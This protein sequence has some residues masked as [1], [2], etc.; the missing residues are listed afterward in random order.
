MDLDQTK[1]PSL[2][3]AFLDTTSS[4]VE[5]GFVIDSPS[6]ECCRRPLFTW[7][8]SNFFYFSKA[9]MYLFTKLKRCIFCWYCLPPPCTF[10]HMHISISL[11]THAPAGMTRAQFLNV[12]Y[13]SLETLEW[14]GYEGRKKEKEVAA[15][16]LRSGRCLKNVTI[17]S[18]STDSNKK[19]EMLK[20]LSLSFRRSPI[21]Q[22]AFN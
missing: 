12:C 17:S 6:L 20:E 22:I 16:I 19:L 11:N 15:F 13:L 21:C 5:G 8:E 14:E 7:A 4:G 9:S 1:V 10:E 18:T 3:S 2:K